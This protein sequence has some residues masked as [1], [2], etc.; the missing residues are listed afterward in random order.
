M[1]YKINTQDKLLFILLWVTFF[2][3]AFKG[4]QVVMSTGILGLIMTGF[5]VTIMEKLTDIHDSQ[6]KK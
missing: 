5:Y 2:I 4:D 6:T 3:G 1:K